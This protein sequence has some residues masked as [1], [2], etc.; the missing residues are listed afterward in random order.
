MEAAI[1]A[2]KLA[3]ALAR[4]VIENGDKPLEGEKLSAIIYRLRVVDSYASTD[5]DLICDAIRI[6]I[7][8]LVNLPPVTFAPEVW[9][10]IFTAVSEGVI[11]PLWSNVHVER[12]V[13]RRIWFKGA[14]TQ[15]SI[16]DL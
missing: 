16:W 5:I 3:V 14:I 11:E 4:F 1:A 12:T 8:Q 2:R 13:K 7:L 9:V 15:T 6:L 10:P